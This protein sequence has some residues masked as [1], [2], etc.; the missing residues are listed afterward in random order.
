M[1]PVALSEK[2]YTML[3]KEQN[4]KECDATADL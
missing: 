3:N 1:N 4:V 2:T